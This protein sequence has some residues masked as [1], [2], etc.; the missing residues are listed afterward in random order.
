MKRIILALMLVSSA[1]TAAELPTVEQATMQ[2]MQQQRN[3]AVAQAGNA[4]AM[5]AGLRAQMALERDYWA[6]YVAG[7]KGNGK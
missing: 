7:L 5:M 1:A 4:L 3:E 6:K 2:A